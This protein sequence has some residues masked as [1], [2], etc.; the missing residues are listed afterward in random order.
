MSCCD[1][2]TGVF[3]WFD[4]NKFSII[5]SPPPAPSAL[6][7]FRSSVLLDF[8]FL[9][10]L[11]LLLLRTN[12]KLS[13]DDPPNPQLP[14]STPTNKQHPSIE[15][16]LNSTMAH[17]LTVAEALAS[18][19]STAFTIL[20]H[21][22]VPVLD[23][24]RP[25]V[26]AYNNLLKEKVKALSKKLDD[27]N[28]NRQ[29]GGAGAGGA[30]TGGGGGGRVVWVDGVFN[31]LLMLEGEKDGNNQAAAAAAAAA[32]GA[33]GS[34]GGRLVLRPTYKLDGTHLH[35]CYVSKLLAPAIAKA[36]SSTSSSSD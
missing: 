24:T 28:R 5:S 3:G 31:E 23:E 10:L 19:S 17:F 25:V 27:D 4:R 7:S 26:V 29:E 30:G 1:A 34:G 2:R 36:L 22:I 13:T 18:N 14:T 35:P 11:L 12:N 15:A 33:G 21:P 6:I 32:T 8:Y 20:V 16:G 9:L